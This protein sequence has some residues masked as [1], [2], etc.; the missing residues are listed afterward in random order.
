MLACKNGS[1]QIA[2]EL[3]KWHKYEF[4]ADNFMS[5]TTY[6]TLTSSSWYFHM[7]NSIGESNKHGYRDLANKLENLLREYQIEYE[8]AKSLKDQNRHES[9]QTSTS[10]TYLESIEN[11]K[12]QIIMQSTSSSSNQNSI[13]DDLNIP[14]PSM[15]GVVIDDDFRL[16]EN[17]DDLSSLLAGDFL[18]FRKREV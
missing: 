6:Q 3:F 8:S 13:N 12:K 14:S 7:I 1:S 10:A 9:N 16:I 18:F 4:E 2:L 15:N 5:P 17:L 11:I